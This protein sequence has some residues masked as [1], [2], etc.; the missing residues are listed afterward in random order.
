MR[1]SFSAFPDG[2][3]GG[4]LLL[5]RVTLGLPLLYWGIADLAGMSVIRIPELTAAAASVFLI[6]GFYTPF[7]GVVIALAEAWTLCFPATA[8]HAQPWT[9]AFL[10]ALSACL[11]MLGP[12]AWSIDARRFGRKVFEIGESRRRPG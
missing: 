1:H 2:W 8:Q 5:F 11:A 4:G 6:L 9:N 12:G 10:A 7:T 3:P